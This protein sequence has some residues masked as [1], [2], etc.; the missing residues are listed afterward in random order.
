MS[1]Q[2]PKALP[3]RSDERVET[4]R[5]QVHN[6]TALSGSELL[7]DAPSIDDQVEFRPEILKVLESSVHVILDTP[8]E[9]IHLDT[10]R[11]QWR[12]ADVGTCLCQRPVVEL[13]AYGSHQGV[14]RY[15]ETDAFAVGI[16]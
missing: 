3:S 12:S 9:L 5:T 16:E 1:K 10:E 15:P 4:G 13:L 2:Q 14:V 6:G 7:L 8:D 11:A